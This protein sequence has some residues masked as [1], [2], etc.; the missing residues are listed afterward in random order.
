MKK[1][2][3][4]ISLDFE[5]VW[6]IFD[7]IQI[8]DRVAYFDNT[9]SAIPK[10][11]ALFEKNNINVT[12]ATV[13]MLFNENWDEWNVNI[14][15]AIPNY[16]NQKLDPYNYGLKYQKSG[17]DRFFF[18]PNLI[19]QIKSV[20]GQ[21]IGTHTY[22]HYYCLEKG[23]TIEQF[24]ADL[25]QA[26]KMATKFNVELYSLVFPRNQYNKAYLDICSKYHLETVRTNPDSWY[27]D[28]TKP[29]TLFS[30][31]ART[32]DA[33]LPI[34]KKSYSA[35]SIKSEGVVCQ[36]ASR[37]LRPQHKFEFLNSTRLIRIKNEIIHAAKNGEVY[38]LWWHPH[39]FGID[40]VNALKALQ[41][42]ITVFSN[43]RETYGM[44]SL[45]M[46]QISDNC[47]QLK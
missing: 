19:K 10:M 9:L 20:K 12:W 42:I 29:E 47:S 44:E 13:G 45:T 24:D 30:K 37:F 17:F 21:E 15:K 31:L 23:Q 27:W 16:D 33:Y 8:S 34:G 35:D 7:H 43:C 46:K 28:T 25:A 32:G 1:G 2:A 22:S 36:N 18:A 6:G 40:T 5:L 3:L 4:V 26:V 11:L 38:H 41:E 14:P 39:N